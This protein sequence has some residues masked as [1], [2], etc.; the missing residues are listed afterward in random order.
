MEKIEISRVLL[1]MHTY[2]QSH[3]GHPIGCSCVSIGDTVGHKSIDG[4][5]LRAR[6]ICN[7]QDIL[8]DPRTCIYF[9]DLKTRE[10]KTKPHCLLLC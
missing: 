1:P 5:W 3:L 4:F 2:L 10:P 9:C 6:F 7:S 8:T